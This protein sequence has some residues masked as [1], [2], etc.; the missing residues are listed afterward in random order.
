MMK[1]KQLLQG[2]LLAF[3]LALGLF[4][5][6]G[7]SDGGDGDGG[8]GGG[9]AGSTDSSTDT[10]FDLTTSSASG[11]GDG[12][13]GGASTATGDGDDEC[14]DEVVEAAPKETQMLLV[15]DTSES[16]DGTPTGFD[17]TKWETLVDSL[18]VAL[19]A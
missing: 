3:T 18:N 4:A 13:G 16:M 14:G 9:G 19:P 1:H 15:V 6:C 12:D 10:D 11:D 2:S 7:N 17:Q 5:G 8:M